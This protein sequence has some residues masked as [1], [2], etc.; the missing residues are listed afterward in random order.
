MPSSSNFPTALDTF[1]NPSDAGGDT[2][3]SVPHDAQHAKINDAVAA[4]QAKVGIN[5]SADAGSIDKILSTKMPAITSPV[6]AP[7]VSPTNSPT[8]A[9]TGIGSLIAILGADFNAS[10]TKQ[11]TIATNL[12]NLSA[13]VNAIVTWIQAN[14][15]MA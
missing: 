13:K 10:N 1:V 6:D 12:N 11:N 15:W 14:G 2:L 7:G 9:A 5:G 8:D 4:L 3:T